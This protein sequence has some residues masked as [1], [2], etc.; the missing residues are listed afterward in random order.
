MVLIETLFQ[1]LPPPYRVGLLYDIGCQTERSCIKWGFL[2]G[3]MERLTFGISVFHAFGH[4]WYH[5]RLYTLNRQVDYA[6]SEI[7]ENMGAWLLR[8][9]RHAL[10]KQ[11]AAE[12]VLR[13]CG[14][15]EID[16]R[17]E[18]KAQVET[19][20]KP[21]PRQSRNAGKDAVKELIQLRE[22]RDGLKK[23]QHE[24]DTLIEDENTPIDEYTDVKNKLGSVRSRLRELTA[25]IRGKQSA[26]G[27]TDRA[28]LEKLLNDPFL[29][30]RMNALALKQCLRDRLRTRK[31]ELDRLERSFRKQVND[32]KVDAHTA[33]SVKSRKPAIS[34]LA[35]SYN[36]LC[37]TMQQLFNKGKAP[38][39][40]ICPKQLELKGIFDLDVNDTIWEDIRLEEGTPAAPP[41]WLADENVC[42]GIKALLER[43][44]CLEEEV[45]LRQECRSMRVWL[46]EEWRIVNL[47]LGTVD[48]GDITS[49]PDWGPSAEDIL[50]FRNV[51]KTVL[52]KDIP[53]TYTDNTKHDNQL[54]C[55]ERDEESEYSDSEHG[56][57]DM[58]LIDTIDAVHLADTTR[59]EMVDN[60]KYL[61]DE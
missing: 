48:F 12:D 14:K 42:A 46:S 11:K 61:Y 57:V 8:R 54:H 22:T 24:Y 47:A 21:L 41:P 34:K 38:C 53:R 19:Q 7:L 29:T 32:Q 43:D 13:K 44:C 56:E 10:A 60:D 35:R 15:S 6:Q 20:T 39:G 25:K 2:D 37:D 31:F 9:S 1:H 5:Q 51:Q 17:A 36:A 28:R 58:F 4:Q 50:N 59:S 23:R 18:W 40:A 45:R 52:V 26:L 3:Y 33:A 16:L 27:V 49:L 30:A 55:E